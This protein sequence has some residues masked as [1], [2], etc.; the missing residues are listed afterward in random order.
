MKGQNAPSTHG[1]PLDLERVALNG[2]TFFRIF[3]WSST[4]LQG[5]HIQLWHGNAP[6]HYLVHRIISLSVHNRHSGQCEKPCYRS[7]EQIIENCSMEKQKMTKDK[8]VWSLWVLL[9]ILAM[10]P[11]KTPRCNLYHFT[12]LWLLL[13]SIAKINQSMWTAEPAI[14]STNASYHEF[15]KDVSILNLNR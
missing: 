1:K 4:K 9:R 10:D 8:D 5:I 11:C 15:I 2:T 3:C 12:L 14:A 13:L 7:W 6:P